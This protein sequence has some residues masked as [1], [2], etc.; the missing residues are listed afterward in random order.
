MNYQEQYKNYSD[1]QLVYV[2]EDSE[3]VSE[4]REIAHKI[5]KSRKIDNEVLASY[6]SEFYTEYFKK[7][8][9]RTILTN[10]NEVTFPESKYLSK[11]EIKK[12]IKEAYDFIQQNRKDFYSHASSYNMG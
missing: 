9:R 8:F 11:K 2:V 7:Q 1:K 10:M 3:Y 6:A 12:I 5:V 4:A